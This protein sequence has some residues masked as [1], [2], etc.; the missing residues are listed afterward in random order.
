MQCSKLWSYVFLTLFCNSSICWAGKIVVVQSRAL[1]PYEEAWEGFF[2]TKLI[3]VE[4]LNMEG[5]AEK[6]KTIMEGFRSE[7]TDM[8]VTIGS[9]ATLMAQKYL[10]D[11]PVIY[12]MILDDPKLT[13]LKNSGVVIQVK[14]RKQLEVIDQ[15]FPGK[16]IGVIYDLNY[17]GQI[18]NEARQAISGLKSTLVPIAINNA[19]E[20]PKALLKIKADQIGS[21]WM[22]ADPTVTK[23]ESIKILI[24]HCLK[25]EVPLVALSAY[26]VN[27]GAF[28]AVSTDFKD[29]G[30]QTA[31]LAKQMIETKVAPPM[32]YPR[33][34]I[35]YVN[36]KVQLALGI[37]SLPEVS[38][39]VIVKK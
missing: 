16:S 10:K 9:E 27:A 34:L 12:T 18:I 23:S 37:M 22:V 24:K 32:E 7:N 6:G 11:I 38:G 13:N 26:H 29:V 28:A 8:V 21:L 3:S 14:I 4:K 36:T 30:A 33:Q 25:E 17:S 5:D 2:S 35:L 31:R 20:L 15:L 1:P 39:T 19:D